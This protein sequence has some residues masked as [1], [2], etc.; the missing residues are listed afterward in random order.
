MKHRNDSFIDFIIKSIDEHPDDWYGIYDK[1]GLVSWSNKNGASVTV[2]PYLEISCISL[3]R[4]QTK[5][6]KT[7]FENLAK[8]KIIKQLSK[9][10]TL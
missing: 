10:Q 4:K 3:T 7:A 6:I 2:S 8:Y 5:Y 9:S 1:F